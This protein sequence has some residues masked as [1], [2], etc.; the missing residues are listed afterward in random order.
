[1]VRY[2]CAERHRHSQ[3]LSSYI[4]IEIEKSR[5]ENF[6]N[7]LGRAFDPCLTASR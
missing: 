7:L 1:M 5:I 4:E 2:E 6:K 3:H